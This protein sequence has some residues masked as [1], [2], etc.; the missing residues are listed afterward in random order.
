MELTMTNNVCFH[1][2]NESEITTA[3]G[4]FNFN[5]CVN[6]AS[7]VAAGYVVGSVGAIAAMLT[8]D[9]TLSLSSAKKSEDMVNRGKA[10]I[11]VGLLP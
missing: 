2:L 6:G 4:G 3:G 9:P 1:E 11:A 10:M 5:L 8:K 7:C